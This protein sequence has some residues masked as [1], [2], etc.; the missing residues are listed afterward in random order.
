LVVEFVFQEVRLEN[1]MGDDRAA[2]MAWMR[3]KF[4][5]RLLEVMIAGSAGSSSLFAGSRR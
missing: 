2:L 1:A 4:R 5:A 3:E